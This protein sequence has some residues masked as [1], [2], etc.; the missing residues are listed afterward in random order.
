MKYHKI[1][2]YCQDKY[3]NNLG[4]LKF[5]IHILRN[6]F[7]S[8]FFSSSPYLVDNLLLFRE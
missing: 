1:K 6:K 2:I 5:V 8:S 7:T 3:L 4:M